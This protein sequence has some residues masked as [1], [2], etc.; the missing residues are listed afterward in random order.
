M[1]YFF[2]SEAEEELLQAIDYYENQSNGL[3]T[4]FADEFYKNLNHIL[5]YPKA[6]PEITDGIRRK[7]LVKFPFGILY[8]IHNESIYIIAIAHL[9]RKPNYWLERKRN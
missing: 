7:L 3:G 5:I 8:S 2:H 9:K 6:W 4:Q 1:Q